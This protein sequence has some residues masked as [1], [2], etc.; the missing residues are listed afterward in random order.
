LKSDAAVGGITMQ[1][2]RLLLTIAASLSALLLS[3]TAARAQT[4]VNYYFL[5]VLDTEGKPVANAKVETE[6]F[7]PTNSKQTDERGQVRDVPALSGDFNTREFRVSKP[8]Y[9]PYKVTEI[10]DKLQYSY[11]FENIVPQYDY[12]SPIRVV[13]LRVPA[14]ASERE[15]VEAEQHRRELIRA[16][17]AGDFAAVEKLLR[18]GVSPDATDVY[19]IPA[20]LFAAF[21]GNG[22]MIKALLAAGADVRNKEKPG[23]NALLQYIYQTRPKTMDVEIVRSLVKASADVNAADKYGAT[24]LGLARRYDNPELIKLLEEAGAR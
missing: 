11:L 16:V 22:A 19:G 20:I 9:L 14:T 1:T 24:V 10:F 13:L 7:G 15:A 6:G 2:S 8:G 17:K 12:K 4:A 3:A 23:R 18:A 21:K 5:E